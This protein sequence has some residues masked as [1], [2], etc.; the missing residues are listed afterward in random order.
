MGYLSTFLLLILLSPLAW[1]KA[2]PAA[3]VPGGKISEQTKAEI[4]ITT[5]AGTV[6]DIELDMDGELEEA[7][8]NAAEK[9]DIFEPGD[10]LVSLKV[11]VEQL[12]K[13]GKT[14]QGEWTFEETDE[15]GWVYD[16][17]GVEK[18][19]PV[20]YIVSA[21]SGKLLKTEVDE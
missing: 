21:E 13:A 14:L 3:L 19:A 7:S 20:D 18:K 12:K 6:I 15:H 5:A 8:G 16:I 10:K 2:N 9:G 11:A 17:E 4:H 1:S